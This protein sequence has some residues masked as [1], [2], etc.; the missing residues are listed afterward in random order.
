MV[1]LKCNRKRGDTNEKQLLQRFKSNFWKSK[2]I[3]EEFPELYEVIKLINK[4]IDLQ[5]ESNEVNKKLNEL[6][7]E[8]NK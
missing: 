8:K 3:R 2:V 6:N 5:E 4:A 1:L 7:Q